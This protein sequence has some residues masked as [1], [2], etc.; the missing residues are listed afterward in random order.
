MKLFK[1]LYD[2]LFNQQL[3]I[4]R[5]DIV[6]KDIGDAMIIFGDINHRYVLDLDWD[7]GVMDI[8]FNI[9]GSK[10]PDTTN[11]H[12]QY[13]VLNTVKHITKRFVDEID[14]KKKKK[15]KIHTI[16][17]K[18]S[19]FRGG[20]IDENSGKIRDKFFIRYIT[21]EYPNSEVLVSDFGTIRVKL[22]KD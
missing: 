7:K 19:R 13:K 10:I 3:G 18:S 12:K 17:F 8:E 4:Y 21:R 6:D 9:L 14:K 16:V 22:K 1:R 11:L 2:K 20:D 15:K 5:Y